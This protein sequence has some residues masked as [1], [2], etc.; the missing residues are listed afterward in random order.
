M[1][2]LGLRRLL[3]IVVLNLIPVAG[4]AFLGWDAAYILLLY[5]AENLV[6]GGIALIRILTARGEARGPH[7]SGLG[8]RIGLGC[9][10]IVHYGIF[11][12]GHGVF[13]AA[14]ASSLTPTGGDDLWARTFGDRGFQIALLATAVLQIIA[15]V[16]D[17]W[18]TGRWKD[19]SPGLEMFRPYGRIVVLHVTIILG[20][21]GLAV[22]DAPTA[23]VLI[24]CL[25]KLGLELVL[26]FLS[27]SGSARPA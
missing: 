27:S 22:L 23:A 17:W 11:C 9:F 3:L 13:A 19:S 21:W 7:A 6:M 16:R 10:F 25:L 18:M 8:G 14:I 26:G 4:V 1:R 15:L 24:L 12:L 2:K 5:W 20:A